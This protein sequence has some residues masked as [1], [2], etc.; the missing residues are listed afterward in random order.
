MNTGTISFRAD[1]VACGI[2]YRR[3][4]VKPAQLYLSVMLILL[5][6]VAD[7]AFGIS[8]A[9]VLLLS[10]KNSR[11]A[12]KSAWINWALTSHDQGPKLA[13]TSHALSV[14]LLDALQLFSTLTKMEVLSAFER[15]TTK[16][17]EGL[18]EDS[19]C[20]HLKRTSW[21]IFKDYIYLLCWNKVY[22]PDTCF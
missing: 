1:I 22:N 7:T 17:T 18:G 20:V 2:Q 5:T 12:Q 14:M 10:G 3:S 21:L 8:S 19:L 4:R 11:C 15:K 13:L 9:V 16:K 6:A